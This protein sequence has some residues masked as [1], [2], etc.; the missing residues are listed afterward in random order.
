MAWT[1][2]AKPTSSV[3]TTVNPMGREQYDQSTI[4]YDESSVFYDGVNPNMWTDVSKPSVIGWT[5]VA[6]PT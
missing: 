1:P 4:T 2:I 6:K 5:N 3:W